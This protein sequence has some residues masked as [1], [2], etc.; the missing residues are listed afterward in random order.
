MRIRQTKREDKT[1]PLL[2]HKKRKSEK[3][4]LGV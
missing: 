1:N 2:P 4:R 3:D